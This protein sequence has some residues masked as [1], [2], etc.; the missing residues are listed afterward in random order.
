MRKQREFYHK[1]GMEVPGDI[2]GETGSAKLHSDPHRNGEAWGVPSPSPSPAVGVTQQRPWRLSAWEVGVVA[3]WGW[4]H[5][6]R[7]PEASLGVWVLLW[8]G[9]AAFGFA[10]KPMAFRSAH[11]VT[12]H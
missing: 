5:G 1:L 3:Q 12:S 9:Q 11:A 8:D 7:A 2:K 6:P 4:G 10:V